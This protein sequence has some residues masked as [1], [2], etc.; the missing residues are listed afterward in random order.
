MTDANVWHTVAECSINRS[1]SV[2]VELVRKLG[3]EGDPLV[4][5]TALSSRA[6]TVIMSRLDRPLATAEP[7]ITRGSR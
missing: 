7:A 2:E 3:R 1:I 6:R 5:C 4:A